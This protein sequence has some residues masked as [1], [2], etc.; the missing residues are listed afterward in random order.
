MTQETAPAG[1]DVPAGEPQ[2][3]GDARAA[4]TAHLLDGIE[5]L[6]VAEHV[7]RFE[8]AH[9]DLSGRLSGGAA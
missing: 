8:A 2:A 7:A 4:S 9:E 5:E 1:D 6:P 3:S